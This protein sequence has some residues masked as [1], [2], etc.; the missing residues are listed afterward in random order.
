MTMRDDLGARGLLGPDTLPVRSHRLDNGLEILLLPKRNVPTVSYF[1]WYK[2]GSRNERPGITG[3]AHFF[4]HMMF[5][6]AKKY[7]PKEFDRTLESVGGSSNAYTSHDVTVYFEDFPTE[8][9]ETV[10]DL[11]SDRMGSL[12]LDPEL[13]ESE[14]EVVKEE[15]RFRVDNDVFG[16]MEE[17]LSS[18][19]W[20]AHP[21]RWP[22]IG[23]MGDLEAI[24]RDDARAFFRTYYAPTN[25][26]VVAVGDLDP[27]ATLASIERAY[28]DI[29][30]GPPVPEVVDAEP[31]PVGERRVQ[32][33]FPSHLP[34]LLLGHRS[35]A[36]RDPATA[37]VEVIQTALGFGAS[38][39]L[40]PSLVYEGALATDVS[41]GHDLRIEPSAFLVYAE[42][43][44]GVAVERV[45]DAIVSELG[46]LASEG[47]PASELQRAKAILRSHFLGSLA[48]HAGL[49][50]TLGE[51]QVLTGDW[52]EA[53]AFQAR[54]EAT[55]SDDVQRVAATLFDAV[56]RSVVSLRPHGDGEEGGA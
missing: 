25:A 34:A 28:R 32:V 5:N 46:R 2:V 54:L 14:R 56:N 18:L 26:L 44:P 4:E 37:A 11:E 41:V 43:V 9:L 13:F 15:R 31:P 10:I 36:A 53:F 23:W 12:A 27:D 22:V 21:Y 17:A 33:R 42:V 50:H 47:L 38:S 1:T 16:F 48:T 45:E 19:I 52:R 6:G 7:G 24:T 39:R 8:A 55:T 51:Y 40:M 49:A 29:P 3:L 30:A 20:R 35:T